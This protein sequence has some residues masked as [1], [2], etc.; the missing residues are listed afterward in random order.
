MAAIRK[1][2]GAKHGYLRKMREFKH[3]M[4]MFGGG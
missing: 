3:S 4:A 2:F 1:R